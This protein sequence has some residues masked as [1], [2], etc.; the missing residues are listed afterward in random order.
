MLTPMGAGRA[1]RAAMGLSLA[2]AFTGTPRAGAQGCDSVLSRTA[3]AAL[4]GSRVGSVRVETRAPDALPAIVSALD[5]LH[6]RTRESTVQRLLLFA[7][8]DTV[9]TLLVA[10]SMRRLRQ[11]RYLG[12]EQV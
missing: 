9:D 2:I 12:D 5:H 1:V 11:L 4:S 6:I 8:G 10:E 3:L 7:P